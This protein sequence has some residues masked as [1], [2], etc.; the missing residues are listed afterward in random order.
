[1]ISRKTIPAVFSSMFSGGDLSTLFILAAKEHGWNSGA[2][3]AGRWLTVWNT[4]FHAKANRAAAFKRTG[5][6]RGRK[7]G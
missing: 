5:K 7:L 2:G 1:M 4:F 3:A 6:E